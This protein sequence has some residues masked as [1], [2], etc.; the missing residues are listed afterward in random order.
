VAKNIVLVHGA[1]AASHVAMLAQPEK[2]AEFMIQ[3]AA[4]PGKTPLPAVA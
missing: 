2:V 1:W 4:S 3:A